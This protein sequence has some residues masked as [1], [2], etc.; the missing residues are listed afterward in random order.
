MEKCTIIFVEY[1]DNIDNINTVVTTRDALYSLCSSFESSDCIKAYRMWTSSNTIEHKNL[2][3]PK[4][5]FIKWI[6]QFPT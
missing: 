1:I 5:K 2:G 3:F 4:E 6:S